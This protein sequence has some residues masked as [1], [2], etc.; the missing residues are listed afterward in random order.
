MK[1][2]NKIY[3]LTRVSTLSQKDNTSLSFQKKRIEDYCKVYDFKLARIFV[4]MESGGKDV[5]DRTGLSKLKSLIENGDCNTIIVN[6]IDR[7]GRSL[8]QGLLFLKYCEEYNCRVISISE[9]IDTDNPSSK[10]ITNILFSIAE[11]ERDMIKSRLSDGRS[12]TFENGKKPYGNISFGYRKNNKGEIVID[13]YDAKIVSFIFKKMNSYLKNGSITKKKRT[14]RLLKLL[15][16]RGYKFN[17]KDFKY[18]NI[19][20][21]LSNPIYCGLLKWK[22]KIVKS[23]YPT[24]VS[25]RLYNSV[26]L[27]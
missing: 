3:G 17:G 12:K 5:D 9:S 23:S 25:K 26:Q 21:I 14:I 1:S 10:L 22:D 27:V 18:W 15:K 24:I 6:K 11:N 13:N 16:K 2:S 19:N 4:E 8:L 7:L 20:T